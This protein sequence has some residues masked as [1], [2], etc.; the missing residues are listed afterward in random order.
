MVDSAIEAGVKHL[1]VSTV[2]H[3][4]ITALLQHETKRDVEEYL[5]SSPINWTILQ[6]ADDMQMAIPPSTFSAGELAVTW[7]ENYRQSAVDLADVATVAAEVL[8][9][10]AP[11]YFAR[12]E[13]CGLPQSFNG[14]ELAAIIERV[15]GRPI[16]VKPV[17]GEQFLGVWA[18]Q[19]GPPIA[20]PFGLEDAPVAATF[21]ENVIENICTWY[22]SHDFLGNPNVLEWLLGRRPTTLEDYVRRVHATTLAT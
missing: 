19:Q 12:Y 20:A 4:I 16:S 7:S 6:P 1:V 22:N 17:S 5:V 11:H 3:P 21:A 15:C 18:K 13:L 10:G 2:L 8:I 14:H 9:E